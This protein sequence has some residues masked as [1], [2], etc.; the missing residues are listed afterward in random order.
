MF[1]LG[2]VGSHTILYDPTRSYIRSYHFN[3]SSAILNILVKWDHKIMRSY[4]PDH[5]FDNHHQS[6]QHVIRSTTTTVYDIVVH[7]ISL[8]Q[9]YYL[10]FQKKNKNTTYHCSFL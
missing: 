2:S 4:D 6:K 10:P 9:K 1:L 7:R 5:D 3:D 8:S